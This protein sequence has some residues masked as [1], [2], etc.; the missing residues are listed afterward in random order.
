MSISKE[1]VWLRAYCAG[2]AGSIANSTGIYSPREEAKEAASNAV[3]DFGKQFPG[4][5]TNLLPKFSFAS[6]EFEENNA[7]DITHEDLSED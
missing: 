5:M 1:E 7:V 4:A 2:L 6:S 3:E